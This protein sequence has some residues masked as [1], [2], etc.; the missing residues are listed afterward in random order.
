M[1]FSS[2]LALLYFNT[3][4][5]HHV[6]TPT[7]NKHSPAL[8]P[9]PS[10][11]IQNLFILFDFIWL[12]YRPPILQ[13]ADFLNY[14]ITSTLKKKNKTPPET[15]KKWIWQHYLIRIE[16]HPNYCSSI[17]LCS[18]TEVQFSAFSVLA[19]LLEVN[20]CLQS[21]ENLIFIRWDTSFSTKGRQ[22]QSSSQQYLAS[23][24]WSSSIPLQCYYTHHWIMLQ[25]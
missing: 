5:F 14:N 9:I 23:F 20:V 15:V 16:F 25:T 24:V 11:C 1:V 3:S 18:F 6:T 12:K 17:T 22:R 7:T 21:S 4:H 2:L 19:F 13:S 10:V 8:K